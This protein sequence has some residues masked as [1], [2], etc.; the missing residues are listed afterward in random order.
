MR[1]DRPHIS[2]TSSGYGKLAV[3]WPVHPDTWATICEIRT[4][5]TDS[6]DALLI[7]RAKSEVIPQLNDM[8]RSSVSQL[9]FC[10]LALDELRNLRIYHHYL[11]N[12][13][14]EHAAVLAAETSP[15]IAQYFSS[16]SLDTST[17]VPLKAED[18]F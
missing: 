14:P 18:L 12:R 2:Y 15:Y 17:I 8:L 10:R 13:R 6:E 7:P 5:S 4:T 9:S 16:D 1:N 3:L 11:S